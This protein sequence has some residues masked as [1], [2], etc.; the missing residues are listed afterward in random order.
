M[1][2]IQQQLTV[3]SRQTVQLGSHFRDSERPRTE[4]AANAAAMQAAQKAFEGRSSTTTAAGSTADEGK[5]QGETA[6]YVQQTG[7]GFR[8]ELTRRGLLDRL[9]RSS[10]AYRAKGPFDGG[11]SDVPV[12]F[13]F[14][15]DRKHPYEDSMWV[16]LISGH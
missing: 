8:R 2:E 15:E 16:S 3:L 6:G 7:P 10:N 5:E 13:G 11:E 12:C 9:R 4:E 14:A 1:S